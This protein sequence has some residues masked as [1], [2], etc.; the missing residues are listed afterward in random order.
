MGTHIFI[1]NDH[2]LAISLNINTI[3]IPD[4]TFPEHGI[5]PRKTDLFLVVLGNSNADA[6][7]GSERTL[8]ITVLGF[9]DTELLRVAHLLAFELESL[10]LLVHPF[11][12]RVLEFALGED[13]FVFV[14]TGEDSERD[15]A[16]VHNFAGIGGRQFGDDG[17]PDR[18]HPA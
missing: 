12:R 5:D 14:F 8:V 18:L 2:P 15:V 4:P 11:E 9:L 16:T 13:E 17:K 6:L 7:R 10:S 1:I 3:S